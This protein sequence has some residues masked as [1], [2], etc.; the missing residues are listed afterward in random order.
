MVLADFIPVIAVFIASAVT[1]FSD[2]LRLAYS[3]PNQIR[4]FA[5][6]RE[7]SD[8]A[9]GVATEDL[10]CARLSRDKENVAELCLPVG[11]GSVFAHAYKVIAIA[12]NRLRKVTGD[13]FPNVGVEFFR[14]EF[15][16][17]W[18]FQDCVGMDLKQQ[19]VINRLLP[20]FCG[21][22][23]GCQPFTGLVGCVL[24]GP[25]SQPTRQTTKPSPFSSRAWQSPAKSRGLPQF[26]QHSI[27]RNNATLQPALCGGRT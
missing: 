26:P 25:F 22:I 14:I 10:A 19:P 8:F 12:A 7:A 16:C 17:R 9:S 11:V 13:I 23:A 4:S 1:T 15:S 21:Q 6:L 3:V 24:V 18:I 2:L 5:T 20:C 27:R